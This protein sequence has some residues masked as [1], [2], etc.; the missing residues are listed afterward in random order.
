MELDPALVRYV[1]EGTPETGDV[2]VVVATPVTDDGSQWEHD[3]LDGAKLAGF[4]PEQAAF[5]WQWLA[6]F[7]VPAG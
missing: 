6:R 7:V 1:P 3:F 4:R 5:M 2:L